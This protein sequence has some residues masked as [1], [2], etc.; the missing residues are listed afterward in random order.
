MNN[1]TLLI[2]FVC[3]TAIVA[4]FYPQNSTKQ[5]TFTP[6]PTEKLAK[7]INQDTPKSPTGKQQTPILISEQTRSEHT[8]K[9]LW[10]TASK[11]EVP[12]Q[13]L[14]EE[15]L[16]E[17][18]QVSPHA[19]DNLVEGQKVALFIPQTGQEY[20]GTIE[21]NHQQFGGQV[22]VSSGSIEGG[23]QFSSFTVSKGTQS[24]LVMI[25]TNEGIY[26]VEIDNKTGIGTV[27]DDKELDHFRKEDDTLTTPPEGVS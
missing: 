16:V 7:T 27:I 12:I 4:W 21:Q 14:P 5:T 24:T 13:S 2:T 20:T 1:K 3:L 18:I 25:A 9:Q 17:P 11:S 26:Q 6:Q 23:D 10:Q 8:V 15:I 19:F 22:S